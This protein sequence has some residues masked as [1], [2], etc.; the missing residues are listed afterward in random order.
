MDN[1]INGLQRIS[2]TPELAVAARVATRS[3]GEGTATTVARDDQ[4]SLTGSAQA[5]RASEGD[6]E[7][8]PVDQAR[9]ER[10][11]EQI[12]AGSYRIDVERIAGKLL[13]LEASG[14]IA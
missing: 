14:G 7:T 1:K 8:A 9:I 12:A 4:I 3:T 2:V 6:N 5:L 11:R 10:L 13:E